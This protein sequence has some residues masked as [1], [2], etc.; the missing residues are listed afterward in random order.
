MKDLL[1]IY[2]GAVLIVFIIC[3]ILL[4]CIGCQQA[5]VLQKDEIYPCFKA[6]DCDYR[7]PKNP[8]KCIDDHKECRA[9]ERYIYCGKDENRWKDCKAQECWDKL[10]SK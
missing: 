2:S 6:R 1:K 7:N 8:E 4:S 9:R 3:F 10:N 5:P